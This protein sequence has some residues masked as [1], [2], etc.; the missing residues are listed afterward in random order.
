[1]LIWEFMINYKSLS[2]WEAWMRRRGPLVILLPWE[3]RDDHKGESSVHAVWQDVTHTADAV[4]TPWNRLL[5]SQTGKLATVESWVFVVVSTSWVGVS[6]VWD[7]WAATNS[8]ALTGH[9]RIRFIWG[10]R[11]SS[12]Q[13][14]HLCDSSDPP[15]TL[16][17]VFILQWHLT[18][19]I[20]H[21]LFLFCL[22]HKSLMGKQYSHWNKRNWVKRKCILASHDQRGQERTYFTRYSSVE[23]W[24]AK[25]TGVQRHLWT[26]YL[27]RQQNCWPFLLERLF[28]FF[29][30]PLWSPRPLSPHQLSQFRCTWTSGASGYGEWSS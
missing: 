25:Q 18:Q 1:M 23:W 6:A 7:F 30:L 22:W 21:L 19:T 14:T 3:V 24:P 29:F 20:P 13:P 9:S 27:W 10:E 2:S 26:V 11:G 28:F 12:R 15:A 16:A 5:Q 4:E 17:E 8:W